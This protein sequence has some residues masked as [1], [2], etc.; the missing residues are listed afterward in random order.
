MCKVTFYQI[1][2]LLCFWKILTFFFKERMTEKCDEWLATGKLE[3]TL[4]EIWS[5]LWEEQSFS[6]KA[7]TRGVLCKKVAGLRSAT[8]SKKRLWHRCFLVNFAKLQNTSGGRFC[9]FLLANLST[10]SD[11]GAQTVLPAKC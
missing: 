5:L 10:S 2:T 3:F 1:L 11:Q 6:A 8:L 7:A 4:G 9:K